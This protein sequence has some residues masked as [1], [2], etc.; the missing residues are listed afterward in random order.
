MDAFGRQVD[1]RN[2][3]VIATSNAGTK[4]I[5]DMVVKGTESHELQKNI[6]EHILEERIFAPEFVNRFDSVV[7]YEPLTRQDLT[8]IA[9]MKLAELK[10]RMAEKNIHI[11]LHD[12]IH[13]KV[14]EDGYDPAFGARPMN[15]VID[16]EIGD[17]ISQAMLTGDVTPGDRILLKPGF[18]RMEYLWEKL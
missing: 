14:A 10:M 3:F 9:R 13:E 12:A 16:M 7:V 11:E 2:N 1:A 8:Q 15:R 5:Q 18:H 17:I 4:L 6:L